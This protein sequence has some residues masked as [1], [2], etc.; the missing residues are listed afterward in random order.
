MLQK[1]L[2]VTPDFAEVHYLIGVAYSELHKNAEA[3]Q[4]FRDVLKLDPDD[5]RAKNAMDL[6]LNVPSI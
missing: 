2:K 4:K 1:L 5:K 6:F 3:I